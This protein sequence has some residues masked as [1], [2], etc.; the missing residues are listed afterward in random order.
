MGPH[1]LTDLMHTDFVT[2]TQERHIKSSGRW[3]SA[4]IAA[5]AVIDPCQFLTSSTM[6]IAAKCTGHSTDDHTTST[7]TSTGL[8]GNACDASGV[9]DGAATPFTSLAGLLAL[10]VMC[11]VAGAAVSRRHAR[12]ARTAVPGLPAAVPTNA[13]PDVAEPL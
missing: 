2:H 6:R 9:N 10:L 3:Y 5:N 4:L 1:T 11:F 12:K 13:A 7:S 8:F